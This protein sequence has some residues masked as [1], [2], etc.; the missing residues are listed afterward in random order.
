MLTAELSLPNPEVGA[1]DMAASR[2]NTFLYYAF[3]CELFRFGPLKS[4][5]PFSHLIWWCYL[6]NLLKFVSLHDKSM[7]NHLSLFHLIIPVIK[8][9]NAKRAKNSQQ[10]F[11]TQLLH[12]TNSNLKKGQK[13]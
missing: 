11:L 2:A 1:A 3:L 10:L 12:L 6:C 7:L 8:M 5:N 9:D 13:V 4:L